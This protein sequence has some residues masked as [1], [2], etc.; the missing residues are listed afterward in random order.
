MGHACTPATVVYYSDTTKQRPQRLQRLQPTPTGPWPLDRAA[1]T[2]RPAQRVHQ[3]RFF[4]SFFFSCCTLEYV[5]TALFCLHVAEQRLHQQQWTTTARHALSNRPRL[6]GAA[7]PN[8]GGGGGRGFGGGR[9]PLR[10][11]T[12]LLTS[13]GSPMHINPSSSN[14]HPTSPLAHHFCHVL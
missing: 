6:P 11:S 9:A 2:F 7:V 8:A 5:G 10:G 14:I 1:V 13:R 4:F 12:H 3:Q